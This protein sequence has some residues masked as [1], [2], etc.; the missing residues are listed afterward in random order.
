MEMEAVDGQWHGG[1]TLAE[2]EVEADEDELVR[3]YGELWAT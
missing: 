3:P 2:D 1:R